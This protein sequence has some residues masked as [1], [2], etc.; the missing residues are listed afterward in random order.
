MKL[1]GVGEGGEI[2]LNTDENFV[3]MAVEMPLKKL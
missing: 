2:W 1:R 3:C